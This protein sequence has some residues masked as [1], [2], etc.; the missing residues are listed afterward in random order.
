LRRVESGFLAVALLSG[1]A[2]AAPA[3]AASDDV[4]RVEAVGALPMTRDASAGAAPRDGAVRAAV[5][6]AVMRIALAL[7]P[8]GF[9]PPTKIDEL[10]GEP[11]EDLTEAPGDTSDGA[12]DATDSDAELAA[13]LQQ[14]LGDD[15]FE[16]AT[17]FRI[18]EDRGVRPALL[19][20][21]PDAATEYVVVVEVY[22][23]TGRVLD[24]LHATGLLVAPAGDESR[25]RIQFEVEGL[26]SFAGY[27]ALRRTL[28]AAPGVSSAL[29]SEFRRDRVVLVVIADREA[30]AIL[31]ELLTTAPPGLR[32]I[33]LESRDDGATLLVDWNEP[34]PAADEGEEVAP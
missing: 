27:D 4:Q 5:G 20:G 8:E 34:A 12:G 6:D 7:L 11:G 14:V 32:V 1:M 13:W 17:R 24:R 19:S 2:L 26:D 29:P 21:D 25:F 16:Y 31:D 15:P 30:S 9:T 33:P 3:R 22:V 23:D 28:V 10:A 18:L